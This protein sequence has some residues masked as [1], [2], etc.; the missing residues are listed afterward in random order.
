MKRKLSLALA[1]MLAAGSMPAT[2][3]AADF[4]DINEVPWA[5]SSI[6]A[7]ADRNL[8]SGYEDGTFRAKNNVT[9]TECMVMLYNVLSKTNSLQSMDTS[10]MAGYYATFSSM[11]IPTWAQASVLY[12]L[13]L[14]LLTG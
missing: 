5:S 13:L 7:A 14:V 3:L 12:G 10:S 2:A 4:K 11:G 8:I 1:V 6:T 9:Y